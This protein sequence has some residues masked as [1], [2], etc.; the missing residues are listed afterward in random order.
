MAP[1]KEADVKRV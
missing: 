1:L